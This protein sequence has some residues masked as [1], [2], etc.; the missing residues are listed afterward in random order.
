[1]FVTDGEMD[2]EIVMAAATVEDNSEV[3][4]VEKLLD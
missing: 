1:M 3:L 4:G 2:R